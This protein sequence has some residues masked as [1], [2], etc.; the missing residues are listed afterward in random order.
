MTTSGHQLSFNRD[1]PSVTHTET[2]TA[3]VEGWM[4]GYMVAMVKYWGKYVGGGAA[5]CK[6]LCQH[7]ITCRRL[8]APRVGL[9]GTMNARRL[10]CLSISP[11]DRQTVG[12]RVGMKK[13]PDKEMSESVP[14]NVFRIPD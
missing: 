4:V 9:C 14:E 2:H 8:L 12:K 5:T 7:E 10:I 13:I 3:W 1:T 11:T 6:D